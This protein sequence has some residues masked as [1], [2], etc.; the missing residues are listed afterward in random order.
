LLQ[1]HRDRV[2]QQRWRQHRASASRSGSTT[3]A[4]N[5]ANT[6][7]TLT[8]RFRIIMVTPVLRLRNGEPYEQRI[9]GPLAVTAPLSGTNNPDDNSIARQVDPIRRS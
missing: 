6:I 3:P 5:D 8:N 1:Q 4:T 7:A 2:R 9:R